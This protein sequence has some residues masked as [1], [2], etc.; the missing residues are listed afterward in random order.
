MER[1]SQG[2]GVD[3]MKDNMLERRFRK[4]ADMARQRLL[5]EVGAKPQ[6]RAFQYLITIVVGIFGE[7]L[8]KGS[9]SLRGIRKSNEENIK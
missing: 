4:G 6:L 9:A 7:A 5:P 8:V 1:E 3:H 2:S